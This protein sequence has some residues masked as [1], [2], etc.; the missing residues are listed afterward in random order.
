MRHV[1]YAD[2]RLGTVDHINAE[3]AASRFDVRRAIHDVRFLRRVVLSLGEFVWVARK[4][5]AA[6]LSADCVSGA[7]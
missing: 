2:P 4:D 5:D 7:R 1:V 6:A 3:V